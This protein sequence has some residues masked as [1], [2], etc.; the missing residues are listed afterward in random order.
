MFDKLKELNRIRKLQGELRKE[1]EQL[2][3]TVEKRDIKIVFRGDKKIEKLLIDGEEQKELKD[4]LN[5]G[6]KDVDK[7][8]EKQMRGRMGELGLPGF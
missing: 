5:A 8:V 4:L 1:L 2:F 7:K 6:M 3:V